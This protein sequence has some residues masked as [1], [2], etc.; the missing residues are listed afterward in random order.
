MRLVIDSLIVVMLLVVL[1]GVVV[2]HTHR[3]RDK[4][5][6]A[7]TQQALSALHAQTAYQSTVKSA[8]AG[9]EQVLVYIE[10]VWFGEQLPVNQLVE[11]DR[12]WLDLAPPGD[13]ND[14]PPDPIVLDDQQAAFWY[15]PTTGVFRARVA[16]QL[17]E[18]RTLEL[19]NQVNNCELL[20]FEQ[21]PSPDRR[22]MAHRPD[23]TPSRQYASFAAGW[24]N[25]APSVEQP[26]IST[27]QPGPD[28]VRPAEQGSPQVRPRLGDP[29]PT[30]P[31]PRV[32]HDLNSAMPAE[33]NNDTGLYDPNQPGSQSP[34]AET[35]EP[36]FPST[37]PDVP[38][39]RPTLSR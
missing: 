31:K 13:L 4:Q 5:D 34:Y 25:A 8:I 33:N 26:V 9:H 36:E 15:N 22:P 24:D 28:E 7:Q 32:I 27:V 16:P 11:G 12:P 35:A 18:G 19:Y 3:E 21:T 1:G 23:Q 6:L 17:S 14:H 20:G 2:L 39:E 38:V 30:E 10:P 37:G 29:V